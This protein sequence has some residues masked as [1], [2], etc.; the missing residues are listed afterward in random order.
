[1]S[2]LAPGSELLRAG[3]A[4]L[5]ALVLAAF[6]FLALDETALAAREPRTYYLSPGGRDGA[7][8]LS[9]GKPMRSFER[10]F[11]RMQAG[12][13]LV[14]LDG[15]YSAAA[16]TGTMHWNNGSASAQ[17]PAGTATRATVVRAQNPGAV[18]IQGALFI[19]RS[20]RKDSYIRVQGITF[21][22]GGS[23]YNTSFVTL[24]D[25]GFHGPLDVGTNDHDQGNTDNLIEDVWVWTAGARIIAINYRAHRNVWRRVVVRGDGCGTS[26]CSGSGNP[27]VGFTVYDS[28]DVSVQNMLIVDRVLSGSDSPYADF[29]CAQH[30]PDARW[31]FGRNEWLGIMS[32]NAPDVGFYCE[33]DKGATLSPVLKLRDSVF[34]NSRGGGVNLARSGTGHVIERLWIRSGDDGFRFAPE[35]VRSEARIDGLTISGRGRFALNTSVAATGASISGEWESATNQAGCSAR[36]VTGTQTAG[37]D[38]PGNRLVRYGVSGARFGAAGYDDPMPESLW[39]WPN[40]ERIRR[41]MCRATKRGFCADG[42]TLTR[43]LGGE[44]SSPTAPAADAR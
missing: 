3:G 31:Y 13:E 7:D 11:S 42:M 9:P 6:A 16:G 36:C 27:N 12:D 37:A 25:D 5:G 18:T 40:E 26:A 39:P 29:A 2:R 24:K 32:L 30:T 1:M 15:V 44:S 20:T 4:L 38:P 35:L 8:G 23:L 22:G 17:I 10:A 28:M 33:P 43:Y 14:L 21:E 41:D 19:G 34:W